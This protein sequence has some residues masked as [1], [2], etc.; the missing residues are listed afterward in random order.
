MKC[1]DPNTPLPILTRHYQTQVTTFTFAKMSEALIIDFFC[2][3]STLSIKTLGP[4]LTLF[5]GEFCLCKL[6]MHG[7]VGMAD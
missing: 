7:S 1:T 2:L 4:F 5:I 3:R 6:R